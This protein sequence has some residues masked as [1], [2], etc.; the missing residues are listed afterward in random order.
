MH[1][2][3]FELKSAADL[4]NWAFASLI[5]ASALLSGCEQPTKQH[6][7]SIFAFGTLIDITL[8]DVDKNAQGKGTEGWMFKYKF[9][10]YET[11]SRNGEPFEKL[12]DH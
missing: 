1:R 12:I 10:D 3:T 9:V 2:K 11:A 8:Y 4:R 6:N 5:F 7:Y